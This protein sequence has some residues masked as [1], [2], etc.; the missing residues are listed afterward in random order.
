MDA[1]A[2]DRNDPGQAGGLG[3]TPMAST[4]TTEAPPQGGASAAIPSEAFW[5]CT[6]RE[7]SNW[8]SYMDAV[9][10]GTVVRMKGDTMYLG[11]VW[12]GTWNRVTLEAFFAP[13][14]W[15]AMARQ[16]VSDLAQTASDLVHDEIDLRVPVSDR[17]TFPDHYGRFKI[18]PI[19]FAAE[20]KLDFFQSNVVKYVCRHDAKNGDEDL[21]KAIRYL[22][23]YRRFLLG[24]PDW[25]TSAPQIEAAF[26]ELL[27]DAS[28]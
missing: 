27:P 14:D 28:R 11:K 2:L 12:L 16:A 25:A 15:N 26:K 21:A 5:T 10:V 22:V 24:D 18:E 17:V 9:Q 4:M 1:S 3:V 6:T 7:G 23:M 19:Y 13:C 8:D 20:N